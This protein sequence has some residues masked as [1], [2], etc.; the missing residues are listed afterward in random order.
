[1][2]ALFRLQEM[3]NAELRAYSRYIQGRQNSSES[4]E[5]VA[6]APINFDYEET[7]FWNKHYQATMMVIMGNRHIQLATALCGS[8]SEQVAQRFSYARSFLF[9][10]SPISHRPSFPVS[11]PS[12]AP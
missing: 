7:W 1:M 11:L 12:L 2:S 5:L 10:L 8:G 9:L 4:Q 3:G 6:L